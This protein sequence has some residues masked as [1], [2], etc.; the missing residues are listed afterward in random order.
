MRSGRAAYDETIELSICTQS[1]TFLLAS[2]ALLQLTH[3]FPFQDLTRT[4]HV[5][6]YTSSQ[7]EKAG[8]RRKSNAPAALTTAKISHRSVLRSRS[9]Y[10][11]LLQ[12]LQII[13]R[14]SAECHRVTMHAFHGRPSGHIEQRTTAAHKILQPPAGPAGA[15]TRLELEQAPHAVLCCTFRG[16]YTGWMGIQA[17]T[18]HH[19]ATSSYFHFYRWL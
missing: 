7:L 17:S 14:L 1:Q 4:R 11:Q 13:C 18:P 5:T 19:V 2:I 10:L 9:G 8:I 3:R 16:S 15:I 6:H 12:L